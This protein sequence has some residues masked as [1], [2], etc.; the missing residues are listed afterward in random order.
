MRLLNWKK[1]INKMKNSSYIGYHIVAKILRFAGLIWFGDKVIGK[2]NIPKKGRC[3]LAGNHLSDFDAYMLFASTNRP[4]HFLGKKELFEGK[5]AWFFKMMHLIPVDRK[6]KNPEAKKAAIDILEQ[7]K[8]VG[9]FPEGTYHKEDLL[10]PFKPGVI[11]FAEKT[12]APIIPFAMD[13]TFKFRCRPIIK[14]G[15]PI[16]VNEIDAED[17]VAYL[18]IVVREMLIELKEDRKKGNI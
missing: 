5:M 14:F 17:K 6:N 18:E 1:K 16:Y 9:I 12:G 4:V 7:D 8:V 2:E 13:S 11:S 3:I 15:K 10:L